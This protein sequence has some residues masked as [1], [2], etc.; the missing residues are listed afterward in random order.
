MVRRSFRIPALVMAMSLA[1]MP[2][3]APA[4]DRAETLADIRQELS[5]L[6]VEVQRLK[7]ELSTTGGIGGG[8]AQGGS[9]LDRVGAIESAL[10]R[11]TSKTEDLEFRIEQ[12]VRDGTNR[13]GDL[14]FRLCELEAD[15]DISQL[16]EGTTLGGEIGRTSGGDDPAAGGEASPATAETG[17]Q[18]GGSQLAVSEEADFRRAQKALEDG[19]YA[20]AAARFKTFRETYPGGPFSARAGLLRGEALAAMGRTSDAAR[21]YLD[22]Y[23]T[24]PEAPEAPEALYRLGRS[25]GA[26]GQLEAACETLSQ[27]EERYSGT[28]AVAKADAEMRSLGCS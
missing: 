2:V 11:L 13:L 1:L 22:T 18:G 8:L 9:A 4:Q 6:Y 3:A 25:L 16:S 12:V 5:V 20:T 17:A 26:L 28:P 14:E 15:C 7:R 10:E 27:I 23:S 19:E 24:A 21:A